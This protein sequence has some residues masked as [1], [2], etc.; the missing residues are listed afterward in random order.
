MELNLDVKEPQEPQALK[1]LEDLMDQHLADIDAAGKLSD[2][3]FIHKTS[4]NLIWLFAHAVAGME[5][6]EEGGEFVRLARKA[7]KP[8]GREYFDMP[9]ELGHV[10][11]R[12][13]D[14][15]EDIIIWCPKSGSYEVPSW[16]GDTL[17]WTCTQCQAQI[18]A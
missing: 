11:Y 10:V 9:P 17:T 8:S 7:L 1:R 3:E 2:Y 6:N 12:E 18:K 14:R 4:N 5:S 13:V 16:N 15:E